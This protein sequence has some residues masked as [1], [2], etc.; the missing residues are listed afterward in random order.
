MPV[1]AT[2]QESHRAYIR[3]VAAALTQAGISVSDID[4]LDDIWDDGDPIRCAQFQISDERTE[5]VYGHPSVRL[6][7]SEVWGWIM[8]FRATLCGQVIPTP[9]EVVEA[10]RAGLAALPAQ[11]APQPAYRSYSDHD[12][13]ME[14]ELDAYTAQEG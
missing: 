11:E 10:V 14:D 3:A 13:V 1:E 7:W 6:A 12:D 5:H 9:P 8:P 2:L 4:F